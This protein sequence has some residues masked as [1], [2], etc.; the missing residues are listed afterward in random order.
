MI[1]IFKINIMKQ[2]H[3]YLKMFIRMTYHNLTLNQ[4][5]IRIYS[6]KEEIQILTIN[7]MNNKNKVKAKFQESNKSQIKKG[8]N[9]KKAIYCHY[10]GQKESTIKQQM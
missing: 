9:N 10:Q 1:I 6:I 4:Q 5:E 7:I 8:K 3:K 2:S